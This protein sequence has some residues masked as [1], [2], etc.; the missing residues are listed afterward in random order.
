MQLESI[1]AKTVTQLL[2]TYE[3]LLF[4]KDKPSTFTNAHG[5]MFMGFIRKVSPSGK[6]VLELEDRVFREFDLKEVNL[7]Y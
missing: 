1:E 3:K 7:L 6:L 5:K 4:R 2:P